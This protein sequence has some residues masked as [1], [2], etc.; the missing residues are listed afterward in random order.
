MSRE[1]EPFRLRTRRHFHV[2]A[3]FGR[4]AGKVETFY[5][6]TTAQELRIEWNRGMSNLTKLE[7]VQI[8]QTDF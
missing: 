8:M 2:D 3:T 4:V 1:A 6:R 5:A 7:A